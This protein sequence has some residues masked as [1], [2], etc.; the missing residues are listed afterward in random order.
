MKRLFVMSQTVWDRYRWI[1]IPIRPSFSI[2]LTLVSPKKSMQNLFSFRR[3][4]H[5]R[6]VVVENVKNSI[7]IRS[8][9]ICTSNHIYIRWGICWKYFRCLYI[10]WLTA[11]IKNS[12]FL[13]LWEY[14]IFHIRP[15]YVNRHLKSY[16]RSTGSM[17]MALGTLKNDVA[18]GIS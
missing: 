16:L 15:V 17:N 12:F 11:S 8:T 7:V 18:N 9:S 5:F 1:L 4:G 3:Y 10:D 14:Q 13:V 2:C 6:S